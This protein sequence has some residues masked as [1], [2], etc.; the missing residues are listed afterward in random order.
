MKKAISILMLTVLFLTAAAGAS[1][2]ALIPEKFEYRIRKNFPDAIVTSQKKVKDITIVSF[3]ENN[4]NYYAYFNSDN[5]ML[6]TA[7]LIT[8]ENMPIKAFT[9]VRDKFGI[10]QIRETLEVYA[11]NGGTGYYV[12]AKFKNRI[13]V[14]KVYSD[15]GLQ[16]IKER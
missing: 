7:R 11:E 3:T 6:M 13:I 4:K 1:E 2:V 16:I 5:E 12:E 9:T 8:P 14:A 10:S 15:G